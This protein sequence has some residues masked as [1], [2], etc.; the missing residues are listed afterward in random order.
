MRETSTGRLN[1][2]TVWGRVVWSLGPRTGQKGRRGLSLNGRGGHAMWECQMSEI[3]VCNVRSRYIRE[4]V[5]AAAGSCKVLPAPPRQAHPLYHFI[6]A[7]WPQKY[8]PRLYQ[9]RCEGRL[10]SDKAMAFEWAVKGED[11]PKEQ[12]IAMA[13]FIVA[14]GAPHALQLS[15]QLRSSI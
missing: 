1:P 2:D 8:F 15:P 7:C 4:R 9:Q 6:P 5:H 3:I 10:G 14:A 11:T 13:V 12:A